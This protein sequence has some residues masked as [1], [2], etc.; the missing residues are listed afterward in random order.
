VFRN[1]LPTRRPDALIRQL[2]IHAAH[3][4]GHFQARETR[5]PSAREAW[6][7]REEMLQ[8]SP[9]KNTY[10]IDLTSEMHMNVSRDVPRVEH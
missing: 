5:C 4:N 10:L 6:L 1:E 7:Q 8:E 9:A 3:S 2:Q